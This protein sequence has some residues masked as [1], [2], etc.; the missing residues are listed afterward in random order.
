MVKENKRKTSN[1]DGNSLSALSKESIVVF[2][3][4]TCLTVT[5]IDNK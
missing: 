4:K 1:Q 3:I 5:E 2:Q